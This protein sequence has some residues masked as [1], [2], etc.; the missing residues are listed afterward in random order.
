MM[1]VIITEAVPDRLRG[2]LSRWLV[3]VRAGVYV[4]SY[5]PKTRDVLW[6]VTEKEVGEGNAVVVWQDPTE[7]GFDFKTAGHNRRQPFIYEGM[8]LVKFLPNV[9]SP[10]RKSILGDQDT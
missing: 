6:G 1:F 5:T 4:G 2:F 8:R 9:K 3:E 10:L 7:G